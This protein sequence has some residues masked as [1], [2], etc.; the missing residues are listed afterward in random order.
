MPLHS[1]SKFSSSSSSSNNNNKK[2]TAI[3]ELLAASVPEVLRMMIFDMLMPHELGDLSLTCKALHANVFSTDTIRVKCV[4]NAL[5]KSRKAEVLPNGAFRLYTSMCRKSIDIRVIP[6]VLRMVSEAPFLNTTRH[7][8]SMRHEGV[9]YIGRAI[10]IF[11]SESGEIHD[12]R[13]IFNAGNPVLLG[14]LSV[15]VHGIT[16]TQDVLAPFT[17]QTHVRIGINL[18][19]VTAGECFAT[20]HFV[21]DGW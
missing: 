16:Q 21:S 3:I 17:V 18:G 19:A 6:E 7:F 13:N 11:L 5:E 15:R 4:L 2:P 8:I 10:N 1:T 14:A 9:R 12:M 20:L